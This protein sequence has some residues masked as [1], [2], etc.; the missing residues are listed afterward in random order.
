MTSEGVTLNAGI[1][2]EFASDWVVELDGT[3]SEVKNKESVQ[4]NRNSDVFV[5]RAESELWSMDLLGSGGLFD[6][7]GGRVRAAMGAQAREEQF[8]FG[9]VGDEGREHVRHACRAQGR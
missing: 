8:F 5:T 4:N 6:L 3:R 7:P 9:E 1:A 2:W